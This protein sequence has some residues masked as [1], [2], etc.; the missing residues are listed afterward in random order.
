MSTAQTRMRL[1]S[2]QPPASR[3]RLSRIIMPD[4]VGSRSQADRLRSVTRKVQLNNAFQDEKTRATMNARRRDLQLHRQ[5]QADR[6]PSLWST[7][8]SD[9]SP[10]PRGLGLPP[11]RPFSR[12]FSRS[13]S[14]N[15]MPSAAAGE[16]VAEAS[17]RSG[18]HRRP[19]KSEL[20]SDEDRSSY[21]DRRGRFSFALAKAA[22]SAQRRRSSGWQGARASRAEGAEDSFSRGSHVPHASPPL[23]AAAA[24]DGARERTN[25]FQIESTTTAGPSAA[26]ATRHI[27]FAS[28]GEPAFESAPTGGLMSTGAG[29]GAAAR[30]QAGVAPQSRSRRR[31]LFASRLGLDACLGLHPD[32]DADPAQPSAARTPA[33]T[34]AD[35]NELT[36]QSV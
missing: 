8:W 22:G 14:R 7:G 12:S 34:E 20:T 16:A 28:L 4:S 15:Q 26:A 30:H 35:T 32:P 23:D 21:D 11:P 36:A 24:R 1:S 10:P 9:Q 3:A 25:L 31:R 19:I 13:F 29:A 33:R 18:P 27:S 5:R 2:A 6:K 17:V